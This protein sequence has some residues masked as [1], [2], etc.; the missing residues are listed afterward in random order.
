MGS[1]KQNIP[2]E[3]KSEDVAFRR[4]GYQNLLN[5][6]G[7]KRDSST[8]YQHVVDGGFDSLNWQELTD[9]YE[10]NGLFTTIIDAPAE[11][12]V[13]HDFDLGIEDKD[14][15]QFVRNAMDDVDF[16]GSTETA[17][18][19][20][21]LYGG[22]VILMMADD[23]E[24]DLRM[25]LNLRRL[26]AIEELRVYESAVVN[27]DY[28][29]LYRTFG[30]KVGRYGLSKF[31]YPEYYEIQTMYGSFRVHESRLLI[32]RNGKAPERTMNQNYRLWGIPEYHRIKQR[33]RE[34]ITAH[35]DGV[36]LLERSVQAVYKMKGLAQLLATDAGEDQALRRLELIDTA[37]NFLNSIA[38]DQEGEDYSFQ[39]FTLSGI[40]EILDST[41]NMLSAVS[42]IPQTILFGRSPA[43]MNATGQSDLENYYNFVDRIRK[44]S[45]R[46]NYQTFIDLLL[47]AGRNRGKLRDIPD[48]EFSFKPLWN[49]SE[50]EQATIEQTRATTEQTKAQTAQIYVDMGSLDP[51]E[52]RDGLKKS[53]N[54]VIQ[55]LIDETTDE[56]IIETA[57][58][59]PPQTNNPNVPLQ[60]DSQADCTSAA[61]L[62]IKN[63]KILVGDRGDGQGICG[64][65]GKI[66]EGETP[67]DAARRETLEEFG[68]ELIDLIP[69][70]ALEGL[71]EE[72]G[73]P[74]IFASTSFNGE[75]QPNTQEMKNNRFS[76]VPEILRANLF[77]PFKESLGILLNEEEQMNLL[78]GSKTAKNKA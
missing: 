36:K 10:G 61:V 76:E 74:F 49:M 63:G 19:W 27:P 23:G 35:G 48:Y 42:H 17:L 29:S 16:E 56:P 69:L 43:G 55:D 37:R 28:S 67:E 59:V 5:K 60:S 1:E 14:V 4:D 21:R 68:I 8:A 51:T 24:K 30:T 3:E 9:Q 70:G 72:F 20:M 39:S 34:T 15:E 12:A 33:L 41:C 71:P 47:L 25:P 77:K 31:G 52:V 66:E 44:K 6:Y 38:I 11:E 58:I 7:T 45:M 53:E 78:R 46:R 62:V 65:G 18:K 40:K 75:V 22:S 32:H 26:R 50:S 57:P 13:R 73:K 64:P 54:Y 2:K